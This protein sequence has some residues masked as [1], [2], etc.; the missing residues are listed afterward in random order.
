MRPITVEPAGA[1]A[2]KLVLLSM[3]RRSLGVGGQ[4]DEGGGGAQRVGEAHDRPAMGDAADRAEVR[5]DQ[6]PRGER[7]PL[8]R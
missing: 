2:M 1:P 3:R 4:I 5:P 8:P 7:S 6:H